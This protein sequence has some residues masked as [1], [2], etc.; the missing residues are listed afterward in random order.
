MSSVERDPKQFG[1]ILSFTKEGKVP[2][3]S[4]LEDS[5]EFEKEVQYNYE[6]PTKLPSPRKVS[7]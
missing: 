3:G 2:K 1:S 4:K 5:D 7:K 6:L